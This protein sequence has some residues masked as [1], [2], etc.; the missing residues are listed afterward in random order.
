[1]ITDYF[2][3]PEKGI[4]LML[5]S[6]LAL[7]LIT[8]PIVTAAESTDAGLD[9][10]SV[11]NYDPNIDDLDIPVEPTVT[12]DSEISGSSFLPSVWCADITDTKTQDICWVAYRN[13]LEYYERGLLHRTQVIEW[14][15]FSTKVI[16]FV[17]LFL[18]GTGIYFAWVQFKSGGDSQ[19]VN[20]VEVS[21]TGVKVSSPILG[22]IILVLSLAFF[23]LYL[24]YV[25]PI[26]EIF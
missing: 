19:T 6:V 8:S 5:F 24:R 12:G 3:R 4:N 1:M 23:Y 18:V 16:F 7:V 15:H 21:L 2:F 9:K 20:E 11:S 26:T 13:G 25:Y 14:Q 22:V 17:V 10:K